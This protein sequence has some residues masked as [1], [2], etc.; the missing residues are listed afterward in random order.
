MTTLADTTVETNWI[1]REF[2]NLGIRC[3]RTIK[4]FIKTMGTLSNNIQASIL[5]ASENVAEAK[6]IYNMLKNETLTEP[7]ILASHC[8]A[9]LQQIKESKSGRV[10]KMSNFTLQF[11]EQQKKDTLK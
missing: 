11:I 2:K 4:R 5:G 1:N 10:S 8:K 6:A 3:G 7:L 9:T